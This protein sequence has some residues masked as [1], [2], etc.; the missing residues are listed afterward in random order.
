MRKKNF[1]KRKVYSWPTLN[2]LTGDGN[3]SFK[4]IEYYAITLMNVANMIQSAYLTIGCRE[5]QLRFI[6]LSSN[7]DSNLNLSKDIGLSVNWV[8]YKRK[9]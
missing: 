7:E 3:V 8:K 2:L 6:K 5:I 1:D 4:D 9:K